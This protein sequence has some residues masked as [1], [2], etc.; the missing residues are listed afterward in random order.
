M[1]RRAFTLIERIPTRKRGFTLIELLVVI[2]IIALLIAILLPALAAARKSAVNTVCGN[3]LHQIGIAYGIWGADNKGQY[4][5][6]QPPGRWAF[7]HFELDDANGAQNTEH[8]EMFSLPNFVVQ[9]IVVAETLYC[10]YETFFKK[11]KFWRPGAV[12]DGTFVGYM[13]LANYEPVGLPQAEEVVANSMEDA[14]DTLLAADISVRR[15]GEQNP[16]RWYSHR[17]DDK[18]L[19]GFTLYN[20]GSTTFRSDQELVFQF[21]MAGVDVYW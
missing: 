18:G 3:N 13:G 5:E 4:P 20:D 8:P 14:S 1:Q 21:N 7:G 19:G 17:L 11:E 12:P 6:G 9:D 10:P 15:P 2:S 16:Y